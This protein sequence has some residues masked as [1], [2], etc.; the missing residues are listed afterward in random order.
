MS[1]SPGRLLKKCADAQVRPLSNQ[2][3][4]C[5]G[6]C[7]GMAAEKQVRHMVLKGRQD[8][9]PLLSTIARPPS[10]QSIFSFPLHAVQISKITY[11]PNPHSDKGTH[12]YPLVKY[13]C[14]REKRQFL[15]HFVQ[16]REEG[17]ERTQRKMNEK[18]D[19]SAPWGCLHLASPDSWSLPASLMPASMVPHGQAPVLPEP[20]T[21]FMLVGSDDLLPPR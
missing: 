2:I 8:W 14:R 15:I 4:V 3:R 19:H 12:I 13:S 17:W 16:E 1:E 10:Y 20:W 11:L 18:H 6:G 9:E 21:A 5:A 7:L